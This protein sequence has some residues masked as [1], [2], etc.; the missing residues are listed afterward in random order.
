MKKILTLLIML[1]ATLTLAPTAKA[2]YAL[3][4][5]Y[6]TPHGYRTPHDYDTYGK[7][8]SVGCRRS[9]KHN[10]NRVRYSNP[11]HYNRRDHSN[12]SVIYVGRWPLEKVETRQIA[13]VETQEKVGISDIMILSK[14]GVSDN[15]I[16]EK[17]VNTGSVFKLSVEEVTALRREGVSSRVVNYMLNTAR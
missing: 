8:C 17:I 13:R 9:H 12:K 5:S 4:I 14:A 6:G 1:S 2:E 15:T 11:R 3:S 7:Y 10:I 16:I